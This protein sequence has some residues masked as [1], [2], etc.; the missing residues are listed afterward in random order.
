MC[1]EEPSGLGKGRR[2]GN[3]LQG[4]RV[5]GGFGALSGWVPQVGSGNSPS[6]GGAT[7]N[8]PPHC[9]ARVERGRMHVLPR[10]LRQCTRTWSQGRPIHHG[11][12]RLLNIQKGDEVIWCTSPPPE[13]KQSE[14]YMLVVTSLVGWLTLGP[15][16]DNAGRAQDGENM[17]QNPQMSAVFPPPHGATCYGGAT[18]MELNEYRMSLAMSKL[19]TTNRHWA[20]N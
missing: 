16:S 14:R 9:R 17:F 1:G 7:W 11:A 2:K 19:P 6:V 10:P 13:I 18:L 12:S 4:V 5:D 3:I 20:D 8:V 15:G